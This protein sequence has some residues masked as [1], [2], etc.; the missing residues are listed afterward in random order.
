MGNG[1]TVTNTH[2]AAE[3][4]ILAAAENG[5]YTTVENLLLE[6]K[7]LMNYQNL[8]G[9]NALFWA[10]FIGHENIS[11]LLIETYSCNVNIVD[12][13]SWTPLHYAASKG[14]LSIATLLVKHGGVIDAVDTTFKWT[15][16]IYACRNG[17][18]EIVEYLVNVG[19]DIHAIDSHGRDALYWACE[20]QHTAIAE[21]LVTQGADINKVDLFGNVTVNKLRSVLIFHPTFFCSSW[22][23]L[24]CLLL[25]YR[26]DSKD[27][28]HLIEVANA[29]LEVV[30][31]K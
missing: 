27:K 15:P 25:F 26:S 21:V 24:D 2:H 6:D 11:R 7:N 16:L 9:W 23:H 17:R 13:H 3:K 18:Q 29:T 1:I 20:K 22:V 12:T 4:A 8:N 10:V 30:G 14:F 31:F 19:A 5:D 28:E